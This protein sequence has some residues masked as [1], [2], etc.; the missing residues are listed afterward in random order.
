MARVI[1][2]AQ[3]RE[4][5]QVESIALADIV[6]T[7]MSDVAREYARDVNAGVVRLATFAL[8]KDTR[9]MALRAAAEL[10][11]LQGPETAA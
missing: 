1:S 8:L 7:R 3:R 9:E 2:I 5:A 11:S 4:D 6:A 10:R